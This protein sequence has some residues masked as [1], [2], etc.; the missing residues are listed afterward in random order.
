M[1]FFALTYIGQDRNQVPNPPTTTVSG[2]ECIGKAPSYSSP[3][4]AN[5]VRAKSLRTFV[6][7]EN[8]KRPS[9]EKKEEMQKKSIHGTILKTDRQ[10]RALE[11]WLRPMGKKKMTCVSWGVV[12]WGN[13]N[14]ILLQ[15]VTPQPF[16][17]LYQLSFRLCLFPPTYM[18]RSVPFSTRE[19][20][21]S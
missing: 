18:P 12:A 5:L 8:Q 3:R 6:I 10:K 2:M 1:C 15:Q 7:R 9:S 11:K 17:P 14:E 19:P 4:R 16:L 20:P 21:L 13:G